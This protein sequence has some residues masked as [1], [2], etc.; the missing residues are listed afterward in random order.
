MKN[1]SYIWEEIKI[2]DTVN[3][4]NS[5]AFTPPRGAKTAVFILPDLNGSTSCKIQ[6]LAPQRN[7]QEAESWFDLLAVIFG[8]G[9]TVGAMNLAGFAEQTAYSLPIQGLGGS[10]LR[11]VAN[12]AQG[13]TIDAFTIFVIWGMDL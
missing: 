13:S 12:N 3:G 6:V 8:V 1:Q 11:F 10:T 5:R 4:V 7:D 2:P 9:A